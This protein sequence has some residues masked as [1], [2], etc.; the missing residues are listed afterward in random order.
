MNAMCPA[1]LLLGIS[2][3]GLLSSIEEQRASVATHMVHV[4]SP[5]PAQDQSQLIGF[6]PNLVDT[7]ASWPQADPDMPMPS[8]ETN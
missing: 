5:Q 3:G 1:S 4:E 7:R 2:I 8:Y 6:H